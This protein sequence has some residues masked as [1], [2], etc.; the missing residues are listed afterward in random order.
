MV[1]ACAVAVLCSGGAVAAPQPVYVFPVPLARFAS[2]RTQITFRGVNPAQIGPIRVDG[3][4]SGAHS[5]HILPDSDGR[6]GSF[7]PDAPF[8]PGET[9]VVRTGLQI[10]GGSNG[11]FPFRVASPAR[12]NRGAAFPP[13]A[14]V[15]GD[16]ARFRSRPDLAPAA[17]TVTRQS[18]RTA[19]GDIFIGPEVGP[20]QDGPMIV[21]WRGRLIW[22]KPLPHRQ[23]A[24]DFRVQ[25][26]HGK[27]VL[28]WW[29]GK[30]A[31]GIG[32]GRGV[33]ADRSY[34]EIATVHAANG[35]TA[36]LHEFQLTPSG[37]ALVTAYFPVYTDARSVHGSA[38]QVV[39]DCVVQEIDIPT[40]LVLFQWDSLD[41]VPLRGSHGPLKTPYNYFHVNS[42][43]R[44]RDGNLIISGRNTWSV[45]KVDH[46]TAATLWILGGKHSS[47][48]MGRGTQF[49]YQH[50]A[51]VRARGDRLITVYDDGGSPF[52]HNSR[53]VTLRLDFKHKRATRVR[54]YAH[55]PALQSQFEGNMQ[56][57]SNGDEMIGWGQPPFFSEFNRRGQMIFDARFVG[58]NSSY[59]AWRMRWNAT[60]NTLPAI[61][62]ANRGG[63]TTVWASW[64]GATGVT[65]WRVLGGSTPNRLH[66][67][68]AANR[69]DFETAI[70][71]GRQSY[72]AV[73]ALDGRSHVLKKSVTKRT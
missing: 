5:G 15:R 57:L 38:R 2:P 19:K 60:P 30:V 71:V 35:L 43:Q 51:R 66:V 36:D 69:S 34:R 45:Y 23:F 55:S 10:V 17:V 18:S 53:G 54:Q 73:E 11:A 21:D 68:G 62:A 64:N 33:I 26:Y 24:T 4:R 52:V 63:R 40:G 50:D 6:G 58:A 72:V 59:R 8:F 65:R 25:R 12:P 29:E 48:K 13:A 39:E 56:Q 14:R 22:F 32:T 46:R 37:T 3:S 16:I 20:I 7:I 61:A 28:T 31:V 27:P 70:N 9:V 42:V 67:V 1:L 47:F 41:H 49:A 44:D